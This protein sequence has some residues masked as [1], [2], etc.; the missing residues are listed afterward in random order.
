MELAE[1]RMKTNNSSMTDEYATL[2]NT[3]NV[4]SIN[5]RPPEPPGSGT[6]QA[7]LQV[8]QRYLSSCAVW[9]NRC[10]LLLS[11]RCTIRALFDTG[12]ILNFMIMPTIR[13][14]KVR[15][16]PRPH[17]ICMATSNLRATSRGCVTA[18]LTFHGKT[19]KTVEFLVLENLCL[20]LILGT[21]FMQRFSHIT[22]TFDFDKD[23]KKASASLCLMNIFS[24]PLFDCL[25]KDCNTYADE[26]FDNRQ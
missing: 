17:Q 12:G 2:A 18:D 8:E 13:L 10:R 15:Y 7:Y 26:L 24:P 22:F 3:N 6:P 20:D 4:S 9:A 19:Y 21:K 1:S 16:H 11:Q 25:S 5:M 14:I 23:S